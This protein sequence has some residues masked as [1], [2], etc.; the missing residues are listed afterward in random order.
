MPGHVH[1][2]VQAV[3]VSKLPPGREFLIFIIQVHPHVGLHSHESLLDVPEAYLGL[4]LG[5]GHMGWIDN[6]HADHLFAESPHGPPDNFVAVV[7]IHADRR[8]PTHHG[9]PVD[10]ATRVQGQHVFGIAIVH[11]IIHTCRLTAFVQH[12]GVGVED[13]HG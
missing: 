11:E 8:V 10:A 1:Q 3:L 13:R 6:R 5:G 9:G 2:R 7:S 12:V 4:H